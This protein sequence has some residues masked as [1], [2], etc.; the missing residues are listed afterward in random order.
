MS[1]SSGGNR[2]KGRNLRSPS[3]KRYNAEKRHWK[4]K[5]RRIRKA[6]QWNEETRLRLLNESLKWKG[7]S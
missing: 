6:G 7:K 2:K 4:N 1:K 3:M 5:E